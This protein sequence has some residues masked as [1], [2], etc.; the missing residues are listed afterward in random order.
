MKKIFCIISALII[1]VVG[2]FLTTLAVK[3]NEVAAFNDPYLINVYNKATTTVNN[4]SYY[5]ED[6]EYSELTTHVKD[7]LTTSL[8]KIMII[9]GKLSQKPIYGEDN[10]SEYDTV[11]KQSN[12]VIE[13]IYKETQNIVCYQDENSRVISYT[14]LLMIIPIQSH[15]EDIIVYTSK[16][17]DSTLKEEE[18]KTSIPFILKG[19]PENLIKYVDELN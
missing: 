19:N 14:C 13:Y 9:D 2:V 6:K 8:L 12:L 11:M 4:K 10:Y 17:N 3:K 15:Y 1:G 16:N 18:Y 5:A 7:M